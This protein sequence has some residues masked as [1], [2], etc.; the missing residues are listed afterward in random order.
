MSPVQNQPDLKASAVAS[1]LLRYD[2]GAA[3][4]NLASFAGSQLVAR[5]IDDPDLN[6]RQRTANTCQ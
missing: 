6:A 3:H 2:L 5:V 1:G 4:D